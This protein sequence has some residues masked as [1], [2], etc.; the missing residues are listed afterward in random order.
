MRL[1]T[2]FDTVWTD[3]RRRL[4]PGSLIRYWSAEGGYTGGAFHINDVDDDGVVV[5]FG[6]ANTER[7]VGTE[8][9]RRLFASWEGYTER[10]I[11]RAE[12]AKRSANASY[13][14]SLLHW[15]EEAQP[16]PPPIIAAPARPVFAASTLAPSAMPG[17]YEYGKQVINE[18]TEGLARFYGGSVEVS[19]G[20]GMPVHVAAAVGDIAVEIG[21]GASRALRGTVLDLI[22]HPSAKKLLLLVPDQLVNTAATAEQCR[23]ILGRFCPAGCFRVVVLKGNGGAPNLVED[24]ATVAGVLSGLRAGG[25]D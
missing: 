18:A 8:E 14:I 23:N 1:N 15:W 21:A 12:M 7:L 16:L 11:G 10:A 17:E 4:L 6:R 9:F 5:L 20:A 13:V 22:C 2:S 19:F 25:G 3:I 24:A